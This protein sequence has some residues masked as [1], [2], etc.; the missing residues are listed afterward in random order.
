MSGRLLSNRRGGRRLGRNTVPRLCWGTQDAACAPRTAQGDRR[1]PPSPVSVGT[2]S[3]S[4]LTGW[5]F[6]DRRPRALRNIL[7]LQDSFFG[8][9]RDKK[10]ELCARHRGTGVGGRVHSDSGLEKLGSA[11][12]HTPLQQLTGHLRGRRKHP[13]R[14]V[15]AYSFLE[16]AGYKY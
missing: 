9:C 13:F 5:Q 14:S 11:R 3:T 4:S 8:G 12:R 1:W 6:Q 10:R 7:P 15:N 2:E 16:V